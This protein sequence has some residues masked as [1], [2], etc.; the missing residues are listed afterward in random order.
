MPGRRRSKK[1][2]AMLELLRSSKIHP[3]AQWIYDQLKPQFPDL[4]LGTVYRNIKILYDEGLIG[5]AGII[6]GEERF[7]GIPGPH[8]HAICTNCG[9]IMDLDEIILSDLSKPFLKKIPGF[10]IDLR[11]TVFYGLCRNCNT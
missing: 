10:T 6:N 8:A 5:S 4:S 9:K 2:E 11:S 7:D 3:G 1:R